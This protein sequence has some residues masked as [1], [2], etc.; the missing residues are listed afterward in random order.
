MKGILN[1]VFGG[2]AIIAILVFVFLIGP[3][4]MVW[5][6]NSLAQAGGAQFYIEHTLWNYWVSFILIAIFRARIKKQQI[7]GL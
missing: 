5:A 6:V 1:A 2:S 7:R 3:V 4:L